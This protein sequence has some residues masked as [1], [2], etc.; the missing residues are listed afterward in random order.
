[1]HA[2]GS[3]YAWLLPTSTTYVSRKDNG[4]KVIVLERGTPRGTIV[5]AF[6]FHPTKSFQGYRVGVPSLGRYII[7][8]DSDWEE[9]GGYARVDKSVVFNAEGTPFDGRPASLQLYLPSRAALV[10]KLAQ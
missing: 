4:D 8:L 1:M 5:F 2:L 10:L 9:F 3:E 6:N 7:A